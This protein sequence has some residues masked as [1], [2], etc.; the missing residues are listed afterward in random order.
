M[1]QN[2]IQ[3]EEK[4]HW[5]HLEHLSQNPTFYHY[6]QELNEIV[7]H[8]S[9]GTTISFTAESQENNSASELYIRTI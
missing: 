7:M 8:N 9:P 3:G 5:Q 6:Q 1:H 2:Y 4:I